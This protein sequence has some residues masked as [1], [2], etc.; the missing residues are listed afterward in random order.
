MSDQY[1]DLFFAIQKI[2]ML[3]ADADETTWQD[4]N[5]RICRIISKVL[6]YEED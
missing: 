6:G 4:Y 2:Y 1:Y 3:A 5:D